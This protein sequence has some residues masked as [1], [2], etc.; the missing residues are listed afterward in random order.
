MLYDNVATSLIAVENEEKSLH[1]HHLTYFTRAAELSK[2]K[3][4][5]RIS[6]YDIAIILQS[7]VD[8]DIVENPDNQDLYIKSMYYSMVARSLARHTDADLPKTF[9]AE[10]EASLDEQ[11][12]SNAA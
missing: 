6:P 4:R 9:L 10:V 12:N 3:L 8:A 11:I 5:K 2:T 7:L 1:G